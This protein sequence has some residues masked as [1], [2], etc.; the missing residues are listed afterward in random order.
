MAYL[1][2][3]EQR[4]P[5]WLQAGYGGYLLASLGLVLDAIAEGSKQAVRIRF[6]SVAIPDALEE[7]GKERQ[8]PRWTCFRYE[9]D[10]EYGARLG[11]LWQD[12]AWLGTEKAFLDILPAGGFVNFSVETGSYGGAGSWAR[13]W[14]RLQKPHPW[15]SD[16]LWGDPGEWGDGGTWGSTATVAQISNLLACLRPLRPAYAKGW[17]ELDLPDH[18]TSIWWSFDLPY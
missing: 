8:A 5:R 9:T 1:E 2:W 4:A 10:E 16:G 11:R 3:L 6:P 17:V 14:V 15:R 12:R 13:F 18:S 7:L